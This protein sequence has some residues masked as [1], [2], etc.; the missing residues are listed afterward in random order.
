MDKNE[1]KTG[2]SRPKRLYAQRLRGAGIAPFLGFAVQNLKMLT[3]SK[4]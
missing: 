4:F 2:E 1:E 3:I